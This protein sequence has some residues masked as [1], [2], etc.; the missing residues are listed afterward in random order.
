[1]KEVITM[2][3][4]H[5][6]IDVSK[7]RHRACIHNLAQ[8][9]Y[10]GIF[11][12]EVNR[13]GFEKLINTLEKLSTNEE[14]FLI[15]I[16]ATGSYGD[17]LSYYLLSR[18]YKVVGI[19]PYQANQF[20]KAQG[21]IAKTD[22]IDARSLAAQLALGNHKALAIP[23][24]VLDNLRELTRFRADMV[25]DRSALVNQLHETLSS[26]FP[27]LATVFSQLD[28]P[29][30]IALLIAYPG[31]EY[32]SRAGE[33]KI[34]ESLR[35]ASRGKMGE[36]LAKSLVEAAQSSIGVLQRQPALATKVSILGE[37]L[38]SLSAAIGRV[39]K[40]IADLFH[41]LPYKPEDFPVGDISSLATL[42]SEIEDIH[43]FPTLKQFLSHFGWCP[44]SF[45]TGSYNREH[46]RMSHAGNRY[47]RR[48]IWML[49]I[50]AIR[51]VPR[52]RDYFQRRVN[53]GKSKMHVIVAVAR[54]LLSVL[55]AILKNGIPYDPDWEVNRHFAMA[56]H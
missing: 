12:I 1:M 47:V 54:K 18:G 8:D 10:S 4:Y 9:S 26:I 20:R 52:Y 34:A 32:I 30:S 5:I 28:S 11:S 33:A 29:S 7:R 55:Y 46:P 48:I 24:P 31:P 53:E 51:T 25:K 36:T 56:R 19:N 37:R 2:V 21:K 45:Q 27:E 38:V 44:Q 22:S 3:K 49:S 41:K 23:D 13:Q 42:L 50:V 39:E 15:G 43:R 16:E 17:T 14:D 6:G 40:E 35:V